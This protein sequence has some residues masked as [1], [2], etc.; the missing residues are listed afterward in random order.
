MGTKT[1]ETNKQHWSQKT[2]ESRNN[3]YFYLYNTLLRS[4]VVVDFLEIKFFCD[5]IMTSV[6]IF[7]FLSNER[8]TPLNPFQQ[9]KHL[10]YLRIV[11]SWWCIEREDLRR[12][13]VCESGIQWGIKAC[14]SPHWRGTRV[15]SR[16]RS[17]EVI[18]PPTSNIDSS[19]LSVCVN[20][21]RFFFCSL[22]LIIRK[23]THF[24]QMEFMY[25]SYDLI[26][27]NSIRRIVVE[28]PWEYEYGMYIV[29]WL[30]YT[31]CQIVNYIN[32]NIITIKYTINKKIYL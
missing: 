25:G 12:G 6:P 9:Q 8:A 21:R 1:K 13:V 16:G 22:L 7:F 17:I 32:H 2:L 24:V 11:F 3:F 30:N 26:G 4:K 28:Q 31:K 23:Q 5:F 19:S 15:F 20:L 27:F 10:S 18:R 14:P 29:F